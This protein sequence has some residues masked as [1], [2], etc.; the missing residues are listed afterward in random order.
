MPRYT[1]SSSL[2]YTKPLA[3]GLDLTA[4]LDATRIGP[5]WDFAYYYEQL[6][7]YTLL[8]GRIGLFRDKRWSGSLFVDNIANKH[9]I[10]TIN[11]TGYSISIPSLT[12]GSVTQ[13]RTAGL[14]VQFRF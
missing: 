6:A 2:K 4:R 5:M 3:D 14:D 7:A 9:A 13:P 10:T 11:N 8:R 12:R 1:M